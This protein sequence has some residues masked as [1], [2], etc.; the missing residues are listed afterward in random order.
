M[1]DDIGLEVGLRCCYS[2]AVLPAM[3]ETAAQSDNQGS[4]LRDLV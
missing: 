2:S 3:N 1:K 4:Q